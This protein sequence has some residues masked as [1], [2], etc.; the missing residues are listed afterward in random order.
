MLNKSHYHHATF[1]FLI[2]VSLLPLD[3]DGKQGKKAYKTKSEGQPNI[4]VKIKE[5]FY[6]H[7]D[8]YFL[9]Y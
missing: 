1:S 4:Y 7:V 9:F 2:P 6:S 8:V 3:T 5:I